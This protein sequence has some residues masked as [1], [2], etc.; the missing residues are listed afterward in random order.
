VQ[1]LFAV[2]SGGP[3]Y[4]YDV[5]ADGQ[6]F[7]IVTPSPDSTT[8]PVTLVVNWSTLLGK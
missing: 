4:F 2:G 3:G 6:K 5:A 8:A 1:T 7:L